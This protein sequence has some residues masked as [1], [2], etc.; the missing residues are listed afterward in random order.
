MGK[1]QNKAAE[2][3]KLVESKQ[4]A[5]GDSFGR[6]GEVMK[7]LY[8]NGIAP[9]Q[10]GDALTVIRV[11]DKLFRI[12]TRKNAFNESPWQDI[13][14]YGLL[15][16]VRDAEEFKKNQTKGEIYESGANHN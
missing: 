8:P 3:G 9:D 11:I 13:C 10:Y 1:Y 14:G 6:S 5:C 4:E 12:A 7:V 16:A 15:A 2:I